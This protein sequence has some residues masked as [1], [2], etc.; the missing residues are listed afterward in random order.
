MSP[1][2]PNELQLCELT[3]WRPK[4]TK[5]FPVQSPGYGGMWGLRKARILCHHEKLCVQSCWDSGVHASLGTCVVNLCDKTNIIYIWDKL[6]I[7][8]PRLEYGFRLL[9][10]TAQTSP[11]FKATFYWRNRPYKTFLLSL[12]SVVV[13]GWQRPFFCVCRKSHCFKHIVFN[14]ARALKNTLYAPV[15]SGAEAENARDRHAKTLENQTKT[16]FKTP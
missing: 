14:A 1:R 13:L 8:V 4:K 3:T 16:T 12:C 11:T 7:A 10:P 6:K 2:T 9:V 5:D 15:V